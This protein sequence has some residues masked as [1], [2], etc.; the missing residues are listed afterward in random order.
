M[1]ETIRLEEYTGLIQNRIVCAWQ[2]DATSPWIPTEFLLT[3]YITRILVAGRSSTLSTA[4]SSDPNWTQVWRCPGAKEWSCLLGILQHMP[5]PV[6]IVL[7]PDI[8][9]SPR[10]TENL[11]SVL[12]NATIVILRQGVAGGFVAT[13][14]DHVFFP[15]IDKDRDRVLAGALQDMAGR[16]NQRPRGLDIR[17]LLPQLA[18]QGYGLTVADGIWSWYKPADSPPMA[19]LTVQQIARQIQILGHILERTIV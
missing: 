1:T 4:L 11:R 17:G 3:Q 10:L 2:N 18:A 12:T 15:V 8:G 19:T 16:P 14:A 13:D 9:L 5:G 6:L 7:S